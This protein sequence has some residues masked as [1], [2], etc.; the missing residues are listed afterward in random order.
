MREFKGYINRLV[1]A[2]VTTVALSVTPVFSQDVHLTQFYASP[3]YLNPA[4]TGNTR[5][6]R[7]AMTYR[8][9]WPG[10][11]KAFQS[12]VFSY[13]YSL[14]KLNSGFGVL[15]ANDKA[16][17]MGYRSTSAGLSYAYQLRISK[18][19]AI[20]GGVNA[21]YSFHDIDRGR[22]VFNDQLYRNSETSFEN[23]SYER[24]GR[25]LD[26]GAGILVYG[27]SLW[28]GL[29]VFHLNKPN[30]SFGGSDATLPPRYS[31][32]GGKE[33]KMKGSGGRKS[34]SDVNLAFHYQ[35]QD[36][37]DQLDLGFYYSKSALIVGLWYRGLPGVK[38]YQ[39]GYQN[40]DALMALLGYEIA[41][42]RT[43]FRIG[44]SYDFTMSRLATSSA[45]AHEI[46]L[47]YEYARK[48][49]RKRLFV[50]CAKF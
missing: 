22:L 35:T 40:N 27:K 19:V 6:H 38:S 17:T 34:T 3:V 48:K 30:E 4:F 46:S 49:K 32:H 13:D 42:E 24:G 31:V 41:K 26:I 18:T 25:Y 36:K 15:V 29:S 21:S 50:P 33:V 7:A 12:Q 45:G 47:V 43:S 10:I 14:E 44:Y 39:K 20:N 23:L 28:T 8:N 2:V 1:T 9:Q 37:F 11:S 16:G 5:E